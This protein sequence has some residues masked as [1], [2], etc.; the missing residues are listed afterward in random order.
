MTGEYNFFIF[1]VYSSFYLNILTEN[2][3]RRQSQNVSTIL[4]GISLRRR[5]IN[6]PFERLLFLPR[7]YIL[8][9][10]NKKCQRIWTRHLE[11]VF[12]YKLQW[13][14]SL[15]NPDSTLKWD[16]ETRW[17]VIKQIFSFLLPCAD[18]ANIWKLNIQT[19][20]FFCLH[21]LSVVIQ[22]E[23]EIIKIC[24]NKT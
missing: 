12:L 18:T 22:S 8:V 24:Q 6:F 11:K 4:E 3:G 23:D 5:S 10:I 13:F 17:N 21:S 2:K 1:H 20:T 19:L 15:W 7:N 14:R 16:L 9:W